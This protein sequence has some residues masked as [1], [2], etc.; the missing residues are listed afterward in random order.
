MLKRV[1]VSLEF[2]KM[3][4]RCLLGSE[5]LT[6][7]VFCF[8]LSV[9]LIVLSSCGS[10]G[11][12]GVGWDN[13]DD[14]AA[15]RNFPAIESNRLVVT[16]QEVP[17]QTFKQEFETVFQDFEYR[18]APVGESAGI[19][20]TQ[21]RGTSYSIQYENFV[22]KVF[23]GND[24]IVERRL[25]RVFNMHPVSSAVIPGK[26][27]ADDRVL[28]RTQSRATTGLH[29]VLIAEGSGDILFEKV[30]TAAEDWDILSGESD[31]IIIGGARTKTVIFMRN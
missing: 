1:G 10:G 15:A 20:K 19:V 4:D 24:L 23:Q 28:C 27:A 18:G 25:P 9:S 8:V 6:G 17:F 31:E 14:I 5:R 3:Q 7:I 12:G 13:P 30:V 2:M 16:T 29:Y 22:L 26:S 21:I 11:I